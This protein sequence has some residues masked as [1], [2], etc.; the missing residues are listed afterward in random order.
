MS[1]P[2]IQRLQSA[3]G[4]C[5]KDMS[6]MGGARSDRRWRTPA[7]KRG[8]NST[9]SN[10]F[11]TNHEILF[12]PTESKKR[13]CPNLAGTPPCASSLRR[14][15]S[16]RRLPRRNP[17]PAAPKPWRRRVQRMKTGRAQRAASPGQAWVGQDP[18]CPL[19]R[20]SGGRAGPL[21]PPVGRS[22]P[23][24]PRSADN[25]AN[26]VSFG[27]LPGQNKDTTKK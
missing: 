6:P 10:S 13:R 22:G 12:C 3:S 4:A 7:G 26:N 11:Q 9:G 20:D 2:V 8:P 15:D 16:G 14:R 21:G 1:I 18:I 17:Q 19:C 24:L 23:T 27:S 5:S 25:A